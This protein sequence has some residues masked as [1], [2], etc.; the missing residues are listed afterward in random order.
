MRL[1]CMIA[2]N[3]SMK[4]SRRDGL[5]SNPERMEEMHV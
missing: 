3:I 2:I 5:P 1:R 4:N